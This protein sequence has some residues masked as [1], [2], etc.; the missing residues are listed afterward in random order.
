MV[1]PRPAVRRLGVAVAAVVVLTGVAPARARAESQPKITTEPAIDGTPQAGAV[2]TANAAWTG[3]PAPTA[4]WTWLRCA[5]TSGPCSTVAT[6]AARTYR[7]GFADV[8]S[9]LRVRL[10]IASNAGSDEARSDPTAVVAPAAA[11]APAPAPTPGPT[12]IPTPAPTPAPTP[13]PVFD[14]PPAAPP[15][16]PAPV[17]EPSSSRPSLL[18]PFPVIRIK[19]R[20]TPAG[21]RVTLLSVRAP[22]GVR[23]AVVCRGASCGR[24]RFR[25]PPGVR[26][27]RPFERELRAGTRLEI[28]VTRPGYVG[29]LTVIVIRRE[30]APWRSDRCLVP[31]EKRAV[32]CSEV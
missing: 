15:P 26:R 20:L 9:V 22:R 25:P 14:V 5:R 30:A 31:G 27:L 12:P 7:A 17:P 19:G 13:Q 6:G 3:D 21:A 4:T 10:R 24:H 28:A 18:K 2:V 11:P 32:R 29:K 1:A 23:I 16:S 8:G